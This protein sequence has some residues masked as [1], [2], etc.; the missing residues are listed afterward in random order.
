MLQRRFSSQPHVVV[1]K[2]LSES[3]LVVYQVGTGLQPAVGWQKSIHHGLKSAI[4]AEAA[5]AFNLSS[6]EASGRPK[7]IANSRY[8]A[9]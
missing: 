6:S 9:S 8:M 3:S 5:V 7:R 2:V 1:P 4:P